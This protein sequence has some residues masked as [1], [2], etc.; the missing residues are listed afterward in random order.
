MDT[1]LENLEQV[2]NT[3][4]DGHAPLKQLTKREIKTERKPWLTT[5]ILMSIHIKNKLYN[6]FCK[7]KDNQRKE[8]LYQRFKTYRNLLSNL[9]KKVKKSITNCTFKKT[10]KI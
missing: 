3:L 10:K 9:T 2:V 1:S 5:G 7:A 4:L 6:K 8:L